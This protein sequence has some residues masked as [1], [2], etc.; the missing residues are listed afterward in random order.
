MLQSMIRARSI[1]IVGAS[2]TK[3]AAG[4]DK[5]GTVAMNYLLAHNYPGKVY[6]VNPKET[7]IRGMPCYPDLAAIPDEVDLALIAVPSKAS[8]SV[9]KECGT[10]GVKNAI[11]LASGFGEAGE[12]E[13]EAELLA[14]AREGGVRFCGP[15]TNGLISIVN[16]MVCCTSMVCAMESFNKGNIAFLTQS[17][18]I[19]TAVMDHAVAHGVGE[20]EDVRAEGAGQG[21]GRRWW[22][23]I[24]R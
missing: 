12:P 18:A 10:K 24:R 14:A 7:E 11:V 1:A 22:R 15:N 21:R 3:N 8:V 2:Q 6:L 9:M 13:L 19:G 5:L 23:K 16:N 20:A 4:G 17:G